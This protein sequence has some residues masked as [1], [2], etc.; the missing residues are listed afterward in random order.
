MDSENI[1]QT[2][3]NSKTLILGIFLVLLIIG[4]VVFIIYR[5]SGTDR[6]KSSSPQPPSPPPSPQPPSP[7]PSPSPSPGPSCSSS[8][9]SPADVPENC[10]LGY[11][12]AKDGLIA[13]KRFFI[14][15]YFEG[16]GI[17]YLFYSTV[18]GAI[19]NRMD[20][21]KVD[22]STNQ[23]F[24][25]VYKD[26]AAWYKK[27]APGK[28]PVIVGGLIYPHDTIIKDNSLAIQCESSR[29]NVFSGCGGVCG[30][31]SSNG[32]YGSCAGTLGT[33]PSWQGFYFMETPA[34]W[35]NNSPNWI[36]SKTLVIAHSVDKGWDF[37]GGGVA[38]GEK[39]DG[40][41]DNTPFSDKDGLAT[42][43]IAF[44]GEI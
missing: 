30:I 7:S 38:I 25:F 28:T 13:G 3:H 17:N 4:G 33:G 6:S 12:D 10:W 42:F 26:C 37:C 43:Q 44:A 32:F 21:T 40:G 34:T 41:V 19:A 22:N 24:G 20:G 14:R 16:W 29:M 11:N 1:I 18:D 9:N 35:T 23:G 5:S 8:F 39:G 15:G 36:A 31:S 2:K 27:N